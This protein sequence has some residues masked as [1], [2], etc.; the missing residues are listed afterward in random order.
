MATHTGEPRRIR[1]A[2]RREAE[3]HK[4]AA[5]QEA[6]AGARMAVRGV[7]AN[8]NDPGGAIIASNLKRRPSFTPSWVAFALSLLWIFAGAAIFG[9]S[10]SREASLFS[11]SGLPK[12]LTALIGMFLPIGLAWTTS[13][14][15]YRAQQLKFVSEGLMQT[16]LRLI[17]PQEVAT[18]GL[19]S[20]A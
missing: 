4:E 1:R 7:P 19:S 13:Y 18:E 6:F 8:E 14:F 2:S 16:A 12:I 10:L 17:R 15:L 11:S 20:V 3:R 9:P 5:S